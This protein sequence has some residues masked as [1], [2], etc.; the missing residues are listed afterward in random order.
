MKTLEDLKNVTR[1]AVADLDEMTPAERRLIWLFVS[2]HHSKKIEESSSSGGSG[3][4]KKKSKKKKDTGSDLDALLSE[5]AAVKKTSKKTNK[6][7]STKS[8]SSSSLSAANPTNQVDESLAALSLDDKVK[9]PNTTDDSNPNSRV[10]FA[11]DPILHS[12][13]NRLDDEQHGDTPD[14]RRHWEDDQSSIQFLFRN[15]LPPDAFNVI[16]RMIYS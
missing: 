3:S 13:P 6:A 2:S 12:V 11:Q 15:D 10:K 5:G 7:S 14:Y 8:S 4:S 16:I 1:E 9:T